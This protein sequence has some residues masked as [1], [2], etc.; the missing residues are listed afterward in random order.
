MSTPAED[1]LFPTTDL[2]PDMRRAREAMNDDV[3]ECV[4]ALLRHVSECVEGGNYPPAVSRF[5]E[6]AEGFMLDL[7][8][9]RLQDMER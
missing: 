3:S 8:I 2:T 6:N 5:F 9:E 1:H 4:E 7:V